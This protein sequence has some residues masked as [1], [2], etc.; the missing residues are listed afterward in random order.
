MVLVTPF[1]SQL[2]GNTITVLRISEGLK[3]LGVVTEI[4]SSTED[5]NA[6]IEDENASILT[7]ADIIHGFN[8]YYFNG[9]ILKK[10]PLRTP[11]LVTMTGTDLNHDLFNEQRRNAVVQALS[12]A[13][14]VHVFHKQAGNILWQEVPWVKGN[15]FVIPQGTVDFPPVEG[16]VSKE[17]GAFVF[18]LPAGIRR[19]KNIPAAIAML[20]PLYK[21]K[22]TVRLWIAG[23]I[24]DREEGREVEELVRQ[25]QGWVCYLGQ[26]PHREMGAIYQCADVVLNT[27]L[28]EGQSSAILEAMAQGIPVL[29]SDNGGNRDIVSHGRVGF[30]YRNEQEFTHYARRLMGDNDLRRQMGSRGK[31]YVVKHH[32]TE[33]EVREFLSIYR[34]ILA[35]YNQASSCLT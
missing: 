29:V 15:T 32:S 26:I 25:N 4:V 8:A 16:K 24:I 22:P 2:R 30:L 13:R 20:A 6:S 21:Q 12:G 7:Q 10:G 23:P 18:L 17:A 28:S 11:Y 27:S 35:G 9:Y 3:R 34:G 5:G 1:Y 19:V 31:D 33:K 14:A